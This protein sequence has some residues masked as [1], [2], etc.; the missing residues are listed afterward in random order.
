MPLLGPPKACR[1]CLL[2]TGT[3]VSATCTYPAFFKLGVKQLRCYESKS[4][5]ASDRHAVHQPCLSGCCT[6]AAYQ[7]HPDQLTAAKN[8]LSD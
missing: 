4:A 8:Q 7:G 5:C 3:D 2:K 6:T 1:R